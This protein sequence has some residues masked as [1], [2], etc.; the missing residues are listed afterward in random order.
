LTADRRPDGIDL[1]VVVPRVWA[2]RWRILVFMLFAGL[3]AYGVVS[4]V[5]R[6]YRSY[7]TLL[8]PSDS[9]LIRNLVVGYRVIKK[10]PVFGVLGNYHTSADVF[11]A[12]L[13]SRYVHRRIVERYE[14]QRVY[15][16]RNL[17][18]TLRAFDKRFHSVLKPDGTITFWVED[19][20]PRRAHAMAKDFLAEL[21]S[22]N[23][24]VRQDNAHQVH[25][26][27]ARRAREADS[28]LQWTEAALAS[29]QKRNFAVTPSLEEGSIDASAELMARKLELE[30]RIGVL[31]ATHSTSS[32]EVQA[33]QSELIAVERRIAALP[34]VQGELERLARDRM[35][36]QRIV[37]FLAS[38]IEN[39]KIRERVNTPTIEVLDPPGVSEKHAR[40]PRV[41]SVLLTMVLAGIAST[42]GFGLRGADRREL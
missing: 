3:V 17:D 26:A 18:E 28:L 14:L 41:K 2:A 37:L 33:A 15:G 5:P 27:L 13:E 31:T 35:L 1:W 38:E 23:V 34:E 16:T 29:S 21:D 8:P 40:P 25:A 10:F 9:D 11:I 19:R 39:A 36:Q 20:D 12:V 32:D 4:L 7:A 6:W 24:K 22:L 42:I 30:I